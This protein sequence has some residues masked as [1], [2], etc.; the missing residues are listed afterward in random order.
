MKLIGVLAR[1]ERG[2]TRLF[3]TLNDEIKQ[4]I[5]EHGYLPYLIVPPTE[6]EQALEEN[7][8]QILKEQVDLCEGLLLQGG[9]DF[10]PYDQWV[11]TYGREKQIPILGVCLGM[12]TMSFGHIGRMEDQKAEL[13]HGHKEE[14]YVHDIWVQP[15][16]KLFEILNQ[17]Q[18]PV[19]SRHHDHVL[20]TDYLVSAYSKDGV[21]E[22][23]ED[24]TYPFYIGV[25]WHP[26]SMVAYDKVSRLLFD[27]FFASIGGQN[28][29]KGNCRDCKW[30]T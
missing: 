1:P 7:E 16:T 8:I 22:A 28:E 2:K 23:I 14:K 9:E 30:S 25:Q 6:Y 3:W 26:E 21:I 18:L 17:L 24:P 27:A 19:N 5:I 10:Y 4:T 12:Q 11:I 15:G 20:D 29:S 13:H